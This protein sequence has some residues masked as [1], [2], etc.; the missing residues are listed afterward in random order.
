MKPK[1]PYSTRAAAG[2]NGLTPTGAASLKEVAATV[3]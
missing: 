1:V 3:M 2:T